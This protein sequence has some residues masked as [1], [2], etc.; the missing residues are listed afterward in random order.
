MEI[1]DSFINNHPIATIILAMAAIGII[2]SLIKSQLFANKA[3]LPV[4]ITTETEGCVF[5]K[6]KEMQVFPETPEMDFQIISYVNG[7]EFHY[8]S[9]DK[10]KWISKEQNIGDILIEL[11]NAELY[12]VHL[13]VHLRSGQTLEGGPTT[14]RKELL[15]PPQ[16]PS[17]LFTQ[18]RSTHF[19]E[20][21]KLYLL[22]D[23]SR[24][25]SVKAIIPY[26]FYIQ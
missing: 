12:R 20:N 21:Y 16:G 24:D 15:L 4:P 22:E 1:V 25:I 2:T 10:S 23:G 8:P 3:N 19:S 17:D 18:N 11:P 5:M 14:V 7:M 6:L 26:E 9:K 13:T